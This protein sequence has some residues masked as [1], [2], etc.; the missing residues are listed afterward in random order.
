MIPSSGCP[1]WLPDHPRTRLRTGIPT[2]PPGARP[3]P[4][5]LGA[6]VVLRS[7][8]V[9]RDLRPLQHPQQLGLV[10]VQPREQPVQDNEAGPPPKQAIKPR[11]QFG[12]AAPGWLSPVGFE[13]TVKPPDQ[14]SLVLL[15]PALTIGEG[16]ELVDEA[17]G[18][19]PAC[20]RVSPGK[21]DDVSAL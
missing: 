7:V 17:L 13:V 20:D 16:V 19:H 6:D 12:S 10:G 5:H 2:P 1:P 4:G 15:R 8:G 18:V 9:Q 11:P 21:E 14:R 3:A